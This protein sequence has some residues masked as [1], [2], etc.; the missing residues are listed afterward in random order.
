MAGFSRIYVVG[1]EAGFM[2]ADGVN[3]VEAFILVGDADRQWFEAHYVDESLAPIGSVKVVVPAG[4]DLTDSLLDACI[5]FLPGY[6]NDCPSL[7]E[8]QSGLTGVDR[9]DFDAESAV[10]P[11]AWVRLREEARPAFSRMNIWTADLLRL[12]EA[13]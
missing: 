5:A 6:F 12:G 10:I 7:S 2:G 3:P 8:V 9:L 1:G 11:A 4:P 13:W